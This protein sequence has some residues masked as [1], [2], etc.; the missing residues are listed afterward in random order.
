MPFLVDATV[1][2]VVNKRVPILAVS[3]DV[4]WQWQGKY[5]HL[6][7]KRILYKSQSDCLVIIA[8]GGHWCKVSWRGFRRCGD[9]Y[10]TS[11][12][13][14]KRDEKLKAVKETESLSG[15]LHKYKVSSKSR[16]KNL[17]EKLLDKSKLL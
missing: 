11:Q 10:G 1:I 14:P 6:S 2:E 17:G 3:H 7:L 9:T 4:Q 15:M 5:L 13:S 8:C 12:K 16:K